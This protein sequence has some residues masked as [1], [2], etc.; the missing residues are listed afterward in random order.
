MVEGAHGLRFLLEALEALRVRGRVFGQ[1]LDRDFAGEAGIASTVDLAHA[2]RP[3][4]RED[5]VGTEACARL[6]WHEADPARVYSGRSLRFRGLRR[7]PP[8]DDAER[9]GHQNPAGLGGG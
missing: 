7:R 4:E 8:A 2:S 1:D 9:P 6:H 5:L 3:E